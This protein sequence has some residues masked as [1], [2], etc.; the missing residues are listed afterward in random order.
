MLIIASTINN[1]VCSRNL[2]IPTLAK[3]LDSSSEDADLEEVAKLMH[4]EVRE[5]NGG[6]QIP[7]MRFTLNYKLSLKKIFND[8]LKYKSELNRMVLKIL[9]SYIY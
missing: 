7:E 5:V 6:S 3:Q 8:N 4:R 1:A 2:M 9:D